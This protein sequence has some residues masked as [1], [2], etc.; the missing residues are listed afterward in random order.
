M[1]I[2]EGWVAQVVARAPI[3]P[4][5]VGSNFGAYYYFILALFIQIAE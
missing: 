3:D 4:K 1:T 2:K 5:V